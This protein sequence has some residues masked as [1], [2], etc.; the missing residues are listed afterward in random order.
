MS[1]RRQ[2]PRPSARSLAAPAANR[3]TRRAAKH[4]DPCARAT[5][6]AELLQAWSV[7]AWRLEDLAVEAHAKAKLL[8][9]FA[10]SEILAA[11]HR[12]PVVPTQGC[13]CGVSGGEARLLRVRPSADV[14]KWNLRVLHELAHVLLREAY[15]DHTH[16]D[17]WALTLMLAIPR[18]AYRHRAFAT[19][20][21]R[22]VG[23]LR[24]ITASAV[25]RQAA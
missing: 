25:S 2:P 20:V 11:G 24:Q 3:Q 19:H 12:Y 17:V 10:S 18:S 14:Q 13:G 15:P 16:A 1:F 9:P 7:D 6:L 21:P 8:Y 4:R 5:A 22:W 23:S